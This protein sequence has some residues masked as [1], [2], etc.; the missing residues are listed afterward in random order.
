MSFH[1]T[2][3]LGRLGALALG[4]LLLGACAGDSLTA[5]LGPDTAPRADGAVPASLTGPQVVI[6]QIY[7]GGGNSGAT[8][9]NDF[10][11]LFNRGDTPVDVTGW[12]VQ[13]ASAAGSSWNVTTLSGSVAPGGYYL[14]QQ[15]AGSGGTENLP[16]P[17]AIGTAAMSAT[18]GKVVLANV[19]TAVAGACP[20]DGSVVDRVGFG[21]NTTAGACIAEWGARSPA[22][23][24]TAAVL[25]LTDG[26]AYTGVAADD[27]AAAAPAPR[28]SASPTTTCGGG[29][30]PTIARIAVTPATTTLAIGATVTL[31][32]QAFDAADAPIPGVTFLWT[33][34]NAAV[35]TVT[36]A[37]LVTGIGAGTATITATASGVN[38]TATVTVTPST[39]PAPRVVISQVFGGGGNSGA[40]YTNDFVELFNAGDTPVALDGWSVQYASAN[41]TS[42][43]TAALT[44]TI[45]PGGYFLVQLAAGS[46]GTVAL[47]TPDAT[48]GLNLSGSS[49]KV[50]LSNATAAQSGACPTGA[51]VIDRVGYGTQSC[52]TE[53][54]T[55]PTLSATLAAF[56][57]DN[58]CTN[59]G[60]VTADFDV[61]PPAPRNGASP[62]VTCGGSGV[63]PRAQSATNLIINELMGDPVNAESAS[64]GEWF[65]VYNPTAS[66]IDLEGFSILSGGTSQPAHVIN[67]SVIV[68]PFGYAVLGR[69]FDPLRN[70]GLTLD[71]NYFVG[72]STTIWL[73]NNDWLMIVDRDGAR[74]D[75]VQWTTLPRGA[76]KALSPGSPRTVNVDAEPWKFSTS[77]FGDGDYGT[78]GALNT[79]LAL[80]PPPV[81]PNRI[82]FSGRSAGDAPLP[83]GFESQVFATLRD[84]AGTSIETTFAWTSLTP[85]IGAID[86]RGVIR[87]LGAGT[88]R[89]RATAADGTTRVLSLPFE[90]PVPGV[91][92]EYLDH[93]E[94]GTPVDADASNDFVLERREFVSSYNGAKGI[95]NWVAYNL[96]ATHSASGVDRCNCFTFDPE[97]EEAGFARYTTADYTGSGAFAGYGIDRGHLVRSADRTSGTLDNAR[98]YY[99]SNIVPQAADMNQGPWAAFE[100]FLGD[101]ARTEGRE[102]YIYAG[103]AGAI[104]TLKGEGK[105]TIPEFTWKVAVIVPR[106]ARVEDITSRADL[107]V[108]AV[109]MPNTP[110]IRNVPWPTYSVLVDSVETLSG[111]D[112]LSALRDD[113]EIG[114]E[115]GTVAPDAVIGGTLTGTEWTALTVDGSGST[116]GDGDA[117]TYA[118]Q[119]GDGTSATGATATH[120]YTRP[121]T[122]TVQLIVTDPLG[123]ADTTS[124]TATVTAFTS[125]AA[126]IDRLQDEIRSLASSGALRPLDAFVLLVKVEV[127]ERAEGRD[128]D[129][130]ARIALD[131]VQLHL[132]TLE[133]T[134][135]ISELTFGRLTLLT[136]RVKA[137]IGG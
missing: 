95:P 120:T 75:S 19:A 17:D 74:V 34:D 33:S 60:N 101:K 13:Y 12:S 65:E 30:A 15:A 39:G 109:V 106:G 126:G 135:R 53:W 26:C 117:L 88:A 4:G 119:F 70:G 67:G 61:L 21:N 55:T 47:P 113:I 46:G 128:K 114:V 86:E 122:Y 3:L 105:V 18:A 82:T 72:G 38:G 132:R 93:L 68:P 11:E 49:G 16:T 121:G 54:G 111:Y 73:D 103:T 52:A 64:W 51:T 137:S 5:P 36:P 92:A 81:S 104:G 129:R 107:D 79:P 69:G 83:V 76:T 42:W 78:P 87:A 56:R 58:G 130:L 59:T 100:T 110:G 40:L 27:F 125:G 80:T 35:A 134:R 116:D 99:F 127:A 62:T 63:P 77:T 136:D 10:I 7:G 131:G 6:S 37:A 24:N 84:P 98:T 41:G 89:F 71:Y 48:G 97:L 22:P 28:N 96:N 9:R 115:S 118:W 1:P 2:R 133:R 112:L 31:S 91:G 45:A 94:F 66:P 32:A 43:N 44:G 102:V 90:V 8:L 50:L 124:S 123:L 108:I 29:P 85:T 23:S 25:R 20:V 14:V 57:R